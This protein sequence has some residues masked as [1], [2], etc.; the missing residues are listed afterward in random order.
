MAVHEVSA[1]AKIFPFLEAARE[2]D[3]ISLAPGKYFESITLKKQVEIRGNASCTAEDPAHIIS[4]GGPAVRILAPKVVIECLTFSMVHFAEKRKSK[5]RTSSRNSS[6][7]APDSGG[8]DVE[9]FEDHS[10]GSL[11]PAEYPGGYRGTTF[12]GPGSQ[13]AMSSGTGPDT[14]WSPAIKSQVATRR[15]VDACVEVCNGSATN[16]LEVIIMVGSPSTTGMLVEGYGSQV[17]MVRCAVG[18]GLN[19][20]DVRDEG[21]IMLDNCEVMGNAQAG[22]K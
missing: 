9:D 15:D 22:L 10:Q 21:S 20:L 12:S 13:A 8:L 17:V 16:L 5:S 14:M 7:G 4:S 6:Y 3:T 11:Q 19:G 2:G 18:E 1:G